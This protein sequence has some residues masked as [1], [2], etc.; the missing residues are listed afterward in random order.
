VPGVIKKNEWAFTD[1]YSRLGGTASGRAEMAWEVTETGAAANVKLTA[2][3]LKNPM[4]EACLVKAVGRMKFPT[5]RG[6]AVHVT[7]TFNF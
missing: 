7:H 1:C 3:E 5:P 2:S 4:L 6:G